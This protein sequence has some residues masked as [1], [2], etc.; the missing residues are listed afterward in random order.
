MGWRGDTDGWTGGTWGSW[1]T[2][3]NGRRLPP[4][5]DGAG[6]ETD[7]GSKKPSAL[8][9]GKARSRLPALGSASRPWE[10]GSSR[11]GHRARG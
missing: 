5:P 8:R 4:H 3:G 7:A 11:H 9:D 1:V 10:P 2:I 6:R